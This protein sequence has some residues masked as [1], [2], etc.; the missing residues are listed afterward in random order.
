M[1]V[2]ALLV[3]AEQGFKKQKTDLAPT[4][5]SQSIQSDCEGCGT[6]S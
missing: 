2:A 6:M 4:P 5:K 1:V 3:F